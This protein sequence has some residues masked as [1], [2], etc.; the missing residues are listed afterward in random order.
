MKR[1]ILILSVII[2]FSI[3]AACTKIENRIEGNA[4]IDWVDFIKLN[5]KSYDAVGTAV[6]ADPAKVTREIGKVRY[7]VAEVVKNPKYEAKDGDAAFWPK[8]TK[9]Y[10]LDGY[11]D[12]SLVAVKDEKILNGYRLY[13]QSNEKQAFSLRY[14]DMP[15]DKVKKIEIYS[16]QDYTRYTFLRKMAESNEVNKFIA[17]LDKGVQSE[18]VDLNTT[19]MFCAVFYTG[20]TFAYKFQLYFDGKSFYWTPWNTMQLPGELKEYIN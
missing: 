9:I 7:T 11:P 14:K 17:I 19:S 8:G 10:A 5:G 2:I 15:K 4:E 1:L 13:H 12:Y 3:F 20:E 16:I 18:N 6:L